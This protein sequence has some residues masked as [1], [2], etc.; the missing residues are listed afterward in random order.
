MAR[1]AL[2]TILDLGMPGADGL[3]FFSKLADGHDPA[4]SGRGERVNSFAHTGRTATETTFGLGVAADTP[5]GPPG[6]PK[7][8][9][10]I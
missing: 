8:P 10:A 5:L 1:K 4:R 2:Q 6:E 7:I 9:S 3:I